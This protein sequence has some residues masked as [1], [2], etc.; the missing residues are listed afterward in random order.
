MPNN[1]ERYRYIPKRKIIRHPEKKRYKINN[2][3]YTFTDSCIICK[4]SFLS[5][6]PE[7]IYCSKECRNKEENN[8]RY[9]DHRTWEEIHGKDKADRLKN[10]QSVHWLGNNNPNFGNRHWYMN[11]QD[12]EKLI[13]NKKHSMIQTTK[14]KTLE[15]IYGCNRA[16]EIRKNI[17]EG[18]KRNMPEMGTPPISCSYGYS[19]RYKGYFFRSLLELTYIKYLIDNEISFRS[20]ETKHFSVKYTNKDGNVRNYY[21]DFYLEE[22]KEIIEIK[23]KFKIKTDINERLKIKAGKNKY[24][25]KYIVLTEDDIY[26][27]VGYILSGKNIN[28][29]NDVYL[30]KRARR[31]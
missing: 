19:G 30:S 7:S 3:I 25:D 5:I 21:P 29:I 13:I 20:A 16:T 1:L 28:S 18:T 14:G 24:N 23:P 27:L 9:N 6:R 22:T 8:P 11:L 17:S 26:N 12:E 31:R 4:Q 10:N 15:E 2:K